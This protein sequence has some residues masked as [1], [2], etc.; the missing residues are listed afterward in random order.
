M[1]GGVVK[2]SLRVLNALWA[3]SSHTNLSAFFNSLK[4][5][6]PFCRAC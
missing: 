4:K 3:S 2:D 1:I 6:K 5:D